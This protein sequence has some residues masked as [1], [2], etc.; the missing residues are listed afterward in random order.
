MGPGTAD[1]SPYGGSANPNI[2]RGERFILPRDYRLY[3]RFGQQSRWQFLQL[4]QFGC[5]RRASQSGTGAAGRF[6]TLFPVLVSNS[7]LQIP[8]KNYTA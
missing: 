6:Q 3:D 8:M 7:A 1:V 5:G 4:C 2:V